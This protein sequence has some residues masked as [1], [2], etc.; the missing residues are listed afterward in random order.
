MVVS[1]A[2]CNVSGGRIDGRRFAIIDFPEPGDPMS[3]MLWPPAHATSK[4]RFTIS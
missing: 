1:R 2:S 3:S 4:A